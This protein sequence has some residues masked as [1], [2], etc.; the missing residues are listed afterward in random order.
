MRQW[1]A[2]AT[3]TILVLA[4]AVT[5]TAASDSA[6]AA[7]T[8]QPTTRATPYDVKLEPNA[9]PQEV[10]QAK[11][12]AVVDVLQAKKLDEPAKG[13]HIERIVKPLFDFPLMARLA[14]GRTY[15]ARMSPEQRRRYVDLF[16]QHLKRS[17]R[18]KIGL[19]E[20]EQV[21]A[22]RRLEN[23]RPDSDPPKSKRIA[24]VPLQ[25]V[26]SKREIM[27]L[28]KLRKTESR[29]LIYDVEVEGVSIVRSYRAQFRDI[30]SGGGVDELLARLAKRPQ[31]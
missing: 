10:V 4:A 19:Y 21:R 13:S 7:P 5:A 3:L 23:D 26:S 12:K 17:Y 6:A 16:T 1:I 18:G 20:G 9:T 14:V 2:P 27:I 11:W 8:T 25:L 22:P 29:W 15:W 31:S 28:H 24:K 30:L